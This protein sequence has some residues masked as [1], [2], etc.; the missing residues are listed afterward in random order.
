MIRKRPPLKLSVASNN[1]VTAAAGEGPRPLEMA[2]HAAIMV[3]DFDGTI[4]FWS[5]GC[6]RLYGW[7]A[8][9]AI[10]QLSEQLLRA[11]FPLPVDEINAA[12]QGDGEWS[13]ELRHHAQDGEEVVVATSKL[14]Q[15]AGDGSILSVI[16][17]AS[18]VTGHIPRVRPRSAPGS[19]DVACRSAL[20]R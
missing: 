14:L 19:L 4:R 7:S 13:G 8:V 5:E 10:G 11:T 15:R 16:E 20:P 3:C 17:T 18:E 1:T 12:L 6:R 2:E 9:Q